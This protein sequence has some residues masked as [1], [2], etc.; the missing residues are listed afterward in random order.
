M[1]QASNLVYTFML[2]LNQKKMSLNITIQIETLIAID[3]NYLRTIN[4]WPFVFFSFIYS[5]KNKGFTSIIIVQS[6][7][8]GKN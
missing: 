8:N 4:E 1:L 6:E 2:R 7:T 5:Y 3:G